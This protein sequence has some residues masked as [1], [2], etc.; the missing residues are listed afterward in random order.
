MPRMPLPP[1]PAAAFSI[2]GRPMR[3][4]VAAI[5]VGSVLGV[6]LPGTMGTPA[7]SASTFIEAYF[8]G[9]A[10][11]AWEFV[12]IQIDQMGIEDGEALF[13]ETNQKIL[14]DR[15]RAWE[16]KLPALIEGR[17]AVIAVGTAHLSGEDGV[18][19]ALERMGYS[20]REF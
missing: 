2:T 8:D 7:A 5:S 1:P 17:D 18:L 6:R 19:R 16:G 20:V 13:E 12:R 4:T 10:R 11:E 9:R 14:I 3:R 15:N